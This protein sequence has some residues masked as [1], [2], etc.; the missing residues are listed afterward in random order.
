MLV[1]LA[2]GEASVNELAAPFKMSLP[3]VSKH[4]KV[5]ERAGLLIKTRNAQ[6][7]PCRI[8]G[9]QLQQALDWIDQYKQLWD[10]ELDDLDDARPLA[11]QTNASALKSAQPIKPAPKKA[12]KLIAVQAVNTKGKGK[13][14]PNIQPSKPPKKQDKPVKVTKPAKP[15]KVPKLAKTS[16][17]PKIKEKT[18]DSDLQQQIGFDF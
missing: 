13:N 8:D 3:A 5:L 14:Q 9:V 2:Q 11:L 17:K 12:A 15:S 4:I 18:I 10:H 6:Q 7:R 1:R 16:V